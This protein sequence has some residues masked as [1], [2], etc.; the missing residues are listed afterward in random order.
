[1]KNTDSTPKCVIDSLAAMG[2]ERVIVSARLD[3]IDL[4]IAN[5]SRVY[6]LNGAP[7]A[8]GSAEPQRRKYQRRIPDAGPKAVASGDTS[9]AEERRGLFF[10]AINQS[11]A[12]LTIAELKKQFPKVSPKDRSN[13]LTIL[14]AKGQIR[15]AGNAWQAA[16]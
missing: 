3:A 5:L 8:E 10:K 14:K 7:H 15:R 16:A 13:A 6:G 1:M 12:G 4:A 9:D 11:S 2:A